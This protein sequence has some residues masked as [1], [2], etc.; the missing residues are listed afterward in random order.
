M[1]S[2]AEELR[3]WAGKDV[4]V[5]TSTPYL[6]IGRFEEATDTVLKLRDVDVQDISDVSSTKEVYL[7][8]SA[9]LG[10]RINRHSAWIRI[11]TIVSVSPLEDLLHE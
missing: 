9:R 2:M 11:A 7:M 3:E 5:D 6:Y 1:V 4:V 8:S 10:K